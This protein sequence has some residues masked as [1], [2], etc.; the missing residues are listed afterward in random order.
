[1]W[2][3]HK[4]FDKAFEKWWKECM[5]QGW[6]GYKFLSRLKSIK[7]LVKKWNLEVFGDLRL[8]EGDLNRRLQVLDGLEG[9][10]R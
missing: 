3:E 10:S 7:G 6:E 9:S 5:F 1:M 4:D 8:K 2:L